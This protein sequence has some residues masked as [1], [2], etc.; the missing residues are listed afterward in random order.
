MKIVRRREF[1]TFIGAVVVSPRLAR[2]QSPVDASDDYPVRPV[3]VICPYTAGG[4]T[5]IL[6]RILSERLS[7]RFGKPFIVEDHAGAGTMI[8][9]NMVAKAVP[10]GYTLLMGTSTP[11]AINATLHAKLPY[12]PARDFIPLALVADVPSVLVVNPSLPVTTTAE[13]I[14]FAKNHPN[15]L[16]FGSPGPGSPHHLTMELFKTLTGTEMVHVPYKGS[17]QA[18]TDVVAGVIP[19]MFVGPAPS[20]NLIRAGKL[21]AIGISSKTSIPELSGVPPIIDDIPGFEAVAWQMLVAPAATPR[22]IVDRLHVALKQI[23]AEPEIQRKI[24]QLGMIPLD[25]PPI[26]EMQ[27]YINSEIAR[28]GKVVLEAGAKTD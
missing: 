27:R 17:V 1:I 19:L 24:K 13:L 28:W 18:L 16:S 25:T 26:V 9:A 12:D 11:L 15:E 23:E 22:P 7:E 8:G 10:D 4:G 14:K 3:T 5:D 21:R 6:A 20:L 2:A